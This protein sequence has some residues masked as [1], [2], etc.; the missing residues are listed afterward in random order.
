MIKE[1]FRGIDFK[2]QT[3]IIC[4]NWDIETFVSVRRDMR[5]L[6]DALFL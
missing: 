4:F 2:S 3:V 1:T 6:F 5:I